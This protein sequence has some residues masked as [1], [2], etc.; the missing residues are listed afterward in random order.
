MSMVF[1]RLGSRVGPLSRRLLLGLLLSLC[2][3]NVGANPC[4]SM[5]NT[6]D[7]QTFGSTWEIINR[8][9]I[10]ATVEARCE[11]GKTAQRTLLPC[12][13][14]TMQC[15]HGEGLLVK[16]LNYR[17]DPNSFCVRRP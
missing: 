11:G 17:G 7:S 10:T 12:A 8:C 5:E 3:F 13:K 9:R 4:F 6:H 16:P 15:G 1:D 14:S 2:G